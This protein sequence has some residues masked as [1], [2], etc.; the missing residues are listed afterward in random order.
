[1]NAAKLRA[2]IKAAATSA[3]ENNPE[4]SDQRAR[5]FIAA[6]VGRTSVDDPDLSNVI[7]RVLY[8]EDMHGSVPAAKVT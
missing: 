7:W 5:H 6:L 8:P 4:N 3:I 1:M 2:A